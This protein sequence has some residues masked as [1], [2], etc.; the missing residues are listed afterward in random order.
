MRFNLSC[1]LGPVRKTG[2]G[3]SQVRGCSLSGVDSYLPGSEFCDIYM[4]GNPTQ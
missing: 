2:I 4:A 1:S 3:Q